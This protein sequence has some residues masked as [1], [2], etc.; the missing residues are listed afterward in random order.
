VAKEIIALK[1]AGV[2]FHTDIFR[3]IAEQ[4]LEH[5]YEAQRRKTIK[6]CKTHVLIQP[7]NSVVVTTLIDA[8]LQSGAVTYENMDTV[9]MPIQQAV[10]MLRMVENKIFIPEAG[11]RMSDN[12]FWV[13][14]NPNEF[15]SS[16]A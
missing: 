8:A 7:D 1:Q 6:S 10:A 5:Y 14:V 13:E 12:Q 11:L 2:E 3:K 9:P 4:G 16:N 15:N